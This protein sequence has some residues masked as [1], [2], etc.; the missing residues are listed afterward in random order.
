EA[1]FLGTRHGFD[2]ILGSIERFTRT[3]VVFRNAD[4]ATTREHSFASLLGLAVRG[5]QPS[6]E[7]PRARLLTRAGDHVAATPLAIGSARVV[8]LGESH[9]RLAVPLAEIAALTII[10]DDRVFLSDL[11]PV[12]VAERS[13]YSGD[14]GPPLYPFR[15]DESVGGRPLAAGGLA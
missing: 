2:T 14:G 6:K 5:G 12:E 15:T 13:F 11:K 3:G 4:G 7:H 10:G 9:Q 8:L 1:L